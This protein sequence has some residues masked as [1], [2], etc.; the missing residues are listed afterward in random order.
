M[1]IILRRNTIAEPSAILNPLFALDNGIQWQSRLHPAPT[2]VIAHQRCLSEKGG[3][4]GYRGQSGLARATDPQPC[5]AGKDHGVFRLSVSL[6][7]FND[8][9][10]ARDTQEQF[11]TGATHPEA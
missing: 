5:S 6:L 7:R 2:L 9:G 3:W 8:T 11:R 10:T 1:P 4:S